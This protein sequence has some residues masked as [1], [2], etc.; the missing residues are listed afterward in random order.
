MVLF[1]VHFVTEK[2]LVRVPTLLKE[3]I[4]SLRGAFSRKNEAQ[5]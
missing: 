2:A 3:E 5:T 1:V 4:W